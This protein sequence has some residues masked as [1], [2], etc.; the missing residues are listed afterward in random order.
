MLSSLHLCLSSGGI[1][2][3]SPDVCRD[4]ALGTSELPWQCCPSS[5]RL[6]PTLLLGG[7]LRLFSR[8]P[9]FGTGTTTTTITTLSSNSISL[10]SKWAWH[11]SKNHVFYANMA[12]KKGRLYIFPNHTAV[13]KLFPPRIPLLCFL[14]WSYSMSAGL[15]HPWIHPVCLLPS[16][17]ML[18]QSDFF[19]GS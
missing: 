4:P 17:P 2:A 14:P 10:S 19:Q 15:W 5:P 11:K 7:K 6:L 8:R 9:W 3:D 12:A 1:Q 18:L 16:L 13:H